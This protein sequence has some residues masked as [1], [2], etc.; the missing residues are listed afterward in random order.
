MGCDPDLCALG[1]GPRLSLWRGR[2]WHAEYAARGHCAPS[3]CE[4]KEGAQRTQTCPAGQVRMLGLSPCV[5]GERPWAA[6]LGSS[7]HTS[8]Q[9]R[10][11]IT[12]YITHTQH[13]TPNTAPTH[14]QM[15]HAWPAPTCSAST[16]V[17]PTLSSP[18]ACGAPCPSRPPA[19][20]V[21]HTPPLPP[22][23]ITP[24]PPP[25]LAPAASP[26]LLPLPLRPAGLG[27]ALRATH[28]HVTWSAASSTAPAVGKGGVGGIGAHAEGRA[29]VR[30]RLA[31]HERVG[32]IEGRG[33]G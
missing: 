7:P 15:P 33:Q 26:A 4:G 29:E 18:A 2:L 9:I 20:P 19:A 27:G 12:L 16:M 11:H 25:V 3:L 31:G 24:A 8:K 21:C 17:S 13:S 14:I 1:P 6:M 5:C 23:S 22:A 30:L 32:G 28:A 10:V